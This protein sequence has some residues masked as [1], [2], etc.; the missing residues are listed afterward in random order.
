M[1]AIVSVPLHGMVGRLYLGK[2]TG[3]VDVIATAINSTSK[4][5]QAMHPVRSQD[6]IYGNMVA[7]MFAL[8][9]MRL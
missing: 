2:Y 8:L 4:S 6:S 5:Q 9:L 3:I 1:L 7:Y